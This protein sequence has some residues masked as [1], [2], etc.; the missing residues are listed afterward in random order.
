MVAPVYCYANFTNF[1][2]FVLSPSLQKSIAYPGQ[3]FEP[4][5]LQIVAPGRDLYLPQGCMK[6]TCLRDLR[7]GGVG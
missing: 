4:V 5:T 1:H 6:L 7:F 2:R 3:C